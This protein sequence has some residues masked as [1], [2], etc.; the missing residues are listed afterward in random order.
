M[1]EQVIHGSRSYIYRDDNMV[2]T[3]KESQEKD[4]ERDW[5]LRQNQKKHI[6]S[7][8]FPNILSCA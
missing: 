2:K 1:I 3:F 5:M 6:L 7:K 8:T 4:V